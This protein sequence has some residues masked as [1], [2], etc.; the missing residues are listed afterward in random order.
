LTSERPRRIIDPVV[1]LRKP[2]VKGLASLALATVLLGTVF[3]IWWRLEYVYNR[4]QGAPAVLA[5]KSAD[6][7]SMLIDGSSPEGM[8][9]YNMGKVPRQKIFCTLPFDDH[10][11]FIILMVLAAVWGGSQLYL[12][13]YYLRQHSY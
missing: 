6:F 10:R 1:A 2:T 4:P 3:F 13:F 11:L 7:G 5:K 12:A 8:L 9:K